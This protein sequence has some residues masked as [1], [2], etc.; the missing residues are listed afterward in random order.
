MLKISKIVNIKNKSLI[1]I[2]DMISLEWFGTIMAKCKL[3][4]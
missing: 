3:N 4:D 2:I 1:F